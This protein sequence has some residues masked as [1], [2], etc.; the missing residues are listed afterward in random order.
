[1]KKKSGIASILFVIAISFALLISP[2][3]TFA[4][5]NTYDY[6]ALGDSLAA[7]VLYNNTLGNGYAGYLAEKL[8]EKD[9]LG[10]FNNNYAAV[11]YTTDD[12]LADIQN[13]KE[14]IQSEITDAEIITIT[15]GAN[16]VLK[17]F[18]I[19]PEDDTVSFDPQEMT[20]ALKEVG[21]NTAEIIGT[22]KTLNP[23][24]SVYVMEYYNPFP[25]VSGE[26]KTQLV[27]LL[28]M[29]N[30]AIEQASVAT[31]ATLV[32]TAEAMAANATV[33]LPSAENIH[34]SE[35]GY[36]VLGDA[37]WNAIVAGTDTG[38]SDVTLGSSHYAGI[39]WLTDYGIKGYEDG[40]FGVDKALTRP[41]AAI[42]FTQALGLDLP[43]ADEVGNY[44][45][46]VDGHL[47]AEYIAAV[48]QADVFKGSNGN[49][50]PNRELTREQM[51]STLVNAFD[52]EST[53]EDVDINLANVSDTHKASVQTLANLEITN[54]FDDFRPKEA[55]TRGQFA[56]FAKLA[57]EAST[58]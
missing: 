45:E 14:S 27:V 12:V 33:Y 5:S 11:G 2:A 58:K 13:N 35:E 37:F 36:Q 15:A 34:P 46:D 44:F 50:L 39:Q 43:S 18:T 10:V 9:A 48:G 55:V 28:N 54:Q 31:G 1:M 40:A 57:Y 42:M 38:Y 32:P 41:H 6:L 4:K 19:D 20:A 49:F 23:N 29:L 26:I 7:G 3:M 22:I 21:E 51:A 30:G 17:L 25:Y 52:L 24:A 16:D 53:G 8:D 47:Y 56:T